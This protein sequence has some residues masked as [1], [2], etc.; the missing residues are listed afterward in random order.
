MHTDDTQLPEEDQTKVE[1]SHTHMHAHAHSHTGHHHHDDKDGCCG[2][3]CSGA[4][5]DSDDACWTEGCGCCHDD[6]QEFDVDFESDTITQN[7]SAEE[8]AKL[9]NLFGNLE[10][11]GIAEDAEEEEDME[12]ELTEE[13]IALL[14]RLFGTP[15]NNA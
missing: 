10:L 9:Q 1:L 2:G 7:F 6:D 14:Q 11:G 15:W 5:A 13:D 4:C 3:G 8:I 12:K